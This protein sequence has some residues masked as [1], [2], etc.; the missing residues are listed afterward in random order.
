MQV[1]KVSIQHLASVL[2]YV[3]SIVHTTYIV[4]VLWSKWHEGAPI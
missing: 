2:V 1:H 3:Y 4:S